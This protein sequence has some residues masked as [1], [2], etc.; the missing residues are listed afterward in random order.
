MP[1]FILK[2]KKNNTRDF[3]IKKHEIVIAIKSKLEYVRNKMNVALAAIKYMHL[4]CSALKQIVSTKHHILRP[5][6]LYHYN[7]R[8]VRFIWLNFQFCVVYRKTEKPPQTTAFVLP[9]M[10]KT[11]LNDTRKK[12]H[13]RKQLGRSPNSKRKYD[14]LDE[15]CIS[16]HIKINQSLKSIKISNILLHNR[17]YM[18]YALEGNKNKTR[19]RK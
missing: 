14:S 5:P 10:R 1:K 16:Y 9:E 7:M 19:K 4:L 13:Q 6:L 12:I 2:G 17:M 15:I 11:F 18:D 8:N 3:F